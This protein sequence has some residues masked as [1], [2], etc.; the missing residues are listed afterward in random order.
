M[1]NTNTASQS[2]HA[3]CINPKRRFRRT[4]RSCFA[5]E[6]I[7]EVRADDTFPQSATEWSEIQAY[8]ISLQADCGAFDAGK[9][10]FRQYR[11]F[12]RKAY[13]NPIST[14]PAQTSTSA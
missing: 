4:E 9:Y 5:A 10:V 14:W 7:T 3:Y 12:V 11:K 1:L 8:L 6:F 2:F 13:R